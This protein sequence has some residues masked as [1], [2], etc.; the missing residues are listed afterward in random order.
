MKYYDEN[1][2]EVQFNPAP[3]SPVIPLSLSSI[4]PASIAAAPAAAPVA[5]S[6]GS[7]VGTSMGGGELIADGLG[8]AAAAD[9]GIGLG[10]LAAIAAATYL[11]GKEAADIYKG[12]RNSNLAGR[13]TLGIATGGLSEV[14]R[15]FFGKSATKGEET[16]RKALAERGIVIPNSDVKEW[17]NNEKFRQSRNEADLTGKDIKNAASL[18]GIGGYDKLDAAKQEAIAQEALNR[19]LVR[20]HHGQVD[21]QMNPE[22]QKYLETTINGSQNQGQQGQ[23]RSDSRNQQRRPEPRPAPRA[24]LADIMPAETTQAPRYDINPSSLIRNPYL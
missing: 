9:A 7:V 15:P 10:P 12:G 3:Q 14:A 19:K 18:Y 6:A 24:R 2:K 1:G 20:E 23:R 11:G 4:A 13:A 8:G 21:I 16:A 17:E 5:G 22:F